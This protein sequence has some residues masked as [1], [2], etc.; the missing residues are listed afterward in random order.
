MLGNRTPPRLTEFDKQAFDIFV[1]DDHYLRKALAA[2]DWDSIHE[3]LAPYCHGT[4]G[5]PRTLR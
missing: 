5:G 3:V 2:I 1:P 4:K